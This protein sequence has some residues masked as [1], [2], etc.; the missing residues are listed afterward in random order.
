MCLW[1]VKREKK[2]LKK[3]FLL[4]INKRK[5]NSVN[6]NNS[7]E[8]LLCS[9]PLGLSV[10]LS[11]A[12]GRLSLVLDFR[13][14]SFS[15]PWQKLLAALEPSWPLV[16]P[17]GWDRH[18]LPWRF[19]MCSDNRKEAWTSQLQPEPAGPASLWAATM[20][21]YKWRLS[22]EQGRKAIRQLWEHMLYLR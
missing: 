12:G 22:C 21:D 4:F 17:L 8:D 5:N 16:T 11:N 6:T 2:I 7:N 14:L 13:F 15:C 9:L 10:E 19:K 3:T 18:E 20:A 1:S